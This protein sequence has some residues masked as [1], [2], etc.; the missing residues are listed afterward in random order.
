MKTVKF[1]LLA[2]FLMICSSLFAINISVELR[3]NGGTLLSD[4]S[5][6]SLTYYDG[7]WHAASNNG[8][9]TFDIT[10]TASSLTYKMSYHNGTQQK[11]SISTTITTVEFT[12]V[13]T[14]VSLKTSGGSTLSGGTFKHYQNGW[15]G[16]IT[17]N[18]AVE[19]LPGNHTF[20]MWYNNGTQQLS[21]QSISGAT[22]EVA[23]VTVT[24][25]ASLKTSGGA[26]LSG[27]TFRHYQNG[28]SGNIAANTAVELLPGNHTFKMWYNNG[29]QQLSSQSI[30][31][32][33]DEVAFVT[34]TTTVS[35]KTSGGSTLS[36]G[37]FKHYQNGW[38][39]S[40]AA[41]T[42]VELLPGNH[43][44]KMWY[45]NGTQQLSSQ[46]ISGT[47]DE[48]AF[49]TVTTLVSLEDCSNNDLSGGTFKH[50]QN[51]W[52]ASVA[53]NTS[54]ELLPGNHTFKMWFNNGTQ[55]LSSQSISGPSDEVL[56]TATQV[57]ISYSGT[58]KHYQNGWGTYSFG[59]FLLPG[60]YTFKFDNTSVPLT[61]N[62]C[63]FTY[64]AVIVKLISSTSAPIAGGIA[65]AYQGGWNTLGTTNAAGQVL[66]LLSGTPG[67]VTFR[68]NY[69]GK[70]VNMTQNV[71]TNS[72]VVFQTELVSMEL[73]ASNGTTVLTGG[74]IFY[75][76]GW[77]TFGSGTTTTSMEL[78]PATYTFRVSYG[79]ASVQ[80]NQNV[81]SDP[82]VVFQTELVSME[83][84][85][86]DGTTV[87]TGN[88]SYYA[89]GWKTFGSGTST[90][91][92]ELLPK[93]Y[94]FRMHYGGGSIQK[95]QDVGSDPDVVFQTE[96]VTM[97]L[98]AS[99]GT[100]LLSGGTSY[101]A[102]GWKTFGSG[103]STTTMELLPRSYTFRITYQGKSIQKN[104]NVSSD[105][106]VEF[107][108]ELVTMVLESSTG[109]LLSGG[110]S[111]Y[112]G[113]WK[114]FGSGTTTTIMELLPATYTFRVSYG[115]GSMQKNQ[116]VGSDPD[117]I[118]ETVL[119][120]MKLLD[121]VGTELAGDGKYYAN[122]TGWKN[123][124]T[125]QTTASME[126]LPIKYTFR[127]FYNGAHV[128]KKQDIGLDPVVIFTGTKVTINFT[129]DIVYYKSGWKTFTSP[130]TLLPGT[131]KFSFKKTGFGGVQANILVTG[132]SIE[133]SVAYLYLK[134]STGQFLAGGTG[135]Y[136]KSGWKSISGTTGT[137]KGI[138]AVIDGTVGSIP[139]KM[140]YGGSSNQKS[141]DINTNSFVEF[142][143]ELVSMNLESSTG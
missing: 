16:S 10:T 96:L 71:S 135:S 103:T 81:G 131:Y 77:K 20:K 132:S 122:P 97:A 61:I 139:Y 119:A 142:E 7:S 136:Y 114:T 107:Q 49:V 8:D 94:T 93:S 79:G 9:G 41:N 143:T 75:S 40:I 117:V 50:Y 55:Q 6:A 68:M 112:A 47:S 44:F 95:N 11:S 12:T 128:S 59:K 92:M 5:T 100:T 14:T 57:N 45:N 31:G 140:H 124:G 34:V 15:S 91:T 84:L 123:F 102:N 3:D 118:F 125:T 76:S 101:Y 104:Q 36:G 134:K 138:V 121:D 2:G 53:A 27:G 83:L 70:S 72:V 37:T 30:S 51:G 32:T 21:S 52:S 133:K 99:D 54:V 19:L 98:L 88:T 111:F 33:A 105:P 29:T 87:L 129:G 38:S 113:G 28:W 35:L 80:K 39:G 85:A 127:V 66:A 4:G 65:S 64:S 26:T 62:G 109:A 63:T 74:A 23:F 130:M 108:T 120:T 13:A 22:D 42:A 69:Q 82:A 46:S 58:V 25:T 86:S 110:S 24:T 78:L 89:S 43:T 56:F 116:N 48:V 90:T 18:T 106:D 60:N 126:L 115:G 137:N 1:L 141:Q 73:L 67:N 17:A